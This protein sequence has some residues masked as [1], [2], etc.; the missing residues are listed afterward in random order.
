[1][2]AHARNSAEFSKFPPHCVSGTYGQMKIPATQFQNT[3]F[4]PDR[5][6]TNKELDEIVLRV[7]QGLVHGVYF[8]K[9]TNDVS[10]TINFRWLL[11]KQKVTEAVVYG[12]ATEYCLK[13]A[14]MGLLELGIQVYLLED[15]IAAV[16]QLAGHTA[17][18]EMAGAKH[19]KS[20]EVLR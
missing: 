6:Y 2:D 16:D 7:K 18:E 10:N 1:V 17:L 11:E 8:E 9:D 5:V 3:L 14:V 12:V 13:D 4:V 20:C 15:A 19:I